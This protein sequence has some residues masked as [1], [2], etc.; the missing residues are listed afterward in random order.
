MAL[1]ARSI[2]LRN[3]P[4]L[5][6]MRS[7]SAS[8]SLGDG[9]FHY[10]ADHWR[11]AVLISER[12]RPVSVRNLSSCAFELTKGLGTFCLH[13]SISPLFDSGIALQL[14]VELLKRDAGMKVGH[15]AALDSPT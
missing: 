15:L 2:A 8:I 5:P 4:L 10:I 12:L 3:H 6:F 14:H 9:M 13:R 7:I 1:P 11:P